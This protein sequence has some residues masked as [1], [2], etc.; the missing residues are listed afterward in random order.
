MDPLCRRPVCVS[1]LASA[2]EPGPRR[3]VRTVVLRVAVLTF[4]VECVGRRRISRIARVSG[5]IG[6]TLLA[7]T[8][9][10][11]LEEEIVDGAVRIVAVQAVLAHG[12]ML[13]QERAPLLRMAF[14]AIVVDG[15]LVQQSFSI[16]AMRIVA[17]RA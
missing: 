2:V 8:R 17:G 15:G 9:P 5:Q 14:V 12:G 10:R 6:V 4:A 11:D 7:E 3:A 1:M 13:P 16:G